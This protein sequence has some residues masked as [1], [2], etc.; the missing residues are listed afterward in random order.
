MQTWAN[1]KVMMVMEYAKAKC[2]D[3][4]TVAAADYGSA[5]TMVD[6]YIMVMEELGANLTK[7]QNKKMD[8]TAKQLEALAASVAAITPLSRVQVPFPSRLQRPLRRQATSQQATLT[9]PKEKSIANTYKLWSPAAIA[10]RSI[11]PLPKTSVGCYLQM[12]PSIY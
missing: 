6:D 8:A 11:P 2:Q 12:Q 9:K 3:S 7:Q 5:N 10:E 1:L 4:T